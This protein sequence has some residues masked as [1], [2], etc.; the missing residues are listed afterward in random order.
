MKIILGLIKIVVVIVGII[1]SVSCGLFIAV[2]SLFLCVMIA[3]VDSILESN[4]QS[5]C[6][7]VTVNLV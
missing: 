5:E 2:A 4:E 7:I 6:S 1:A 3:V